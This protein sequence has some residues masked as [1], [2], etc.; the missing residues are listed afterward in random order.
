MRAGVDFEGEFVDN[1]RHG[2]G[3]VWYKSGSKYV[4]D[5]VDDKQQGNAEFN[6][7][8]G[9]SFKGA[10]FQGRPTVGVFTDSHDQNFEVE[11]DCDCKEYPSTPF[12]F[13]RQILPD[14]MART[15]RPGGL[16]RRY[17]ERPPTTRCARLCAPYSYAPFQRPIDLSKP[18]RKHVRLAIARGSVE[19][20]KPAR[21][22]PGV[23]SR[24]LRLAR[25]RR[26]S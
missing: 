10:V 21:I 24:T 3:T 19:Q 17:I 1:K 16:C 8:E 6:S 11:Y 9:W 4:G 22:L 25:T 20:D 2:R 18:P 7:F 15:K 13:P 5:F 23:L 26:A 12:P 14:R